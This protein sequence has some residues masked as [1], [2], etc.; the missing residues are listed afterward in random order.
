MA[1]KKT[2]NPRTAE[3]MNMAAKDKRE[4]YGQRIRIFPKAVEALDPESNVGIVARDMLLKYSMG[5]YRYAPMLDVCKGYG[6]RSNVMSDL[7]LDH[8][9]FEFVDKKWAAEWFAKRPGPKGK[10]A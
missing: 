2:D 10:K 8:G 5:F 4:L 1:K 6:L 3:K 9:V 7:R